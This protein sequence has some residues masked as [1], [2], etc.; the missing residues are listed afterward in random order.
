ME[1]QDHLVPGRS[2]FPDQPQHARRGREAPA[3][4]RELFPHKEHQIRHRRMAPHEVRVFWRD[5]PVD[6]RLRVATAQLFQHRERMDH[7][8]HRGGF[9]QQDAGKLRVTDIESGQGGKHPS[10]KGRGP[11]GCTTGCGE[12]LKKTIDPP[13]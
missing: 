4:L 11:Q 13:G 3:G 10:L 8:A 12:R 1:I 5:Q 6:P 2:D 9:D 7:V